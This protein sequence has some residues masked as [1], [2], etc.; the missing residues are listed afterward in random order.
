MN[1]EISSLIYSPLLLATASVLIIVALIYQKKSASC[2]NKVIDTYGSEIFEIN[3][4]IAICIVIASVI[5]S[6]I[7]GISS[8]I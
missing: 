1:S 6:F 8:V 4:G 7:S 5:I 3:M 2:D